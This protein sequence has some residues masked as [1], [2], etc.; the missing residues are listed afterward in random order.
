MNVDRTNKVNVLRGIAPL[1]LVFV[2]LALQPA[3]AQMELSEFTDEQVIEELHR[4]DYQKEFKRRV[5]SYSAEEREAMMEKLRNTEGRRRF[6]Q[7]YTDNELF[8]VVKGSRGHRSYFKALNELKARYKAATSDELTALAER[9]RHAYKA[10]PYPVFDPENPN[11]PGYL[12]NDSVYNDLS[13]AVN[14]LLPEELGLI[15]FREVYLDSGQKGAITQFLMRLRGE[16][17]TGPATLAVLE[18]LAAQVVDYGESEL[19]ALGEHESLG[20]IIANR[21]RRCSDNSFEVVKA[22]EWQKNDLDVYAMGNF[23]E[24]EARALLLEYYATISKDHLYIKSRLRVLDALVVRWDR[25]HD[26]EFRKLLRDEL[27]DMLR[28]DYNQSLARLMDVIRTIEKSDDPYFIPLLKRRRADLD[29]AEI[30]RTSVLP[31][32]YL[33]INIQ[34]TLKCFDQAIATLEEARL[35]QR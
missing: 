34:S 18:E 20:G 17:F 27:T 21:I 1:L 15:L 25:G 24:P 7:E 30:R 26:L 28:Q 4:E 23:E 29:L 11:E 13:A 33:E 31:E 3:D 10:I 5:E 9:L 16:P 22:R 12:A 8:D 19:S 35:A 6:P 32:E 2:S 14:A